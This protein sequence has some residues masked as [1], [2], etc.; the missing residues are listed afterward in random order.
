MRN[1]ASRT[2]P[3]DANPTALDRALAILH[4]LIG[5]EH[6]LGLSEISDRLGIPKP[7][8]HRLLARLQASGHLSRD[9][10]GRSFSVG[11]RLRELSVGAL[12]SVVRQAPQLAALEALTRETGE[13]C[14]VGVLDGDAVVIVERIETSWPIRVHLSSGLRLPLHATAL[15]KLFL[16]RLSRTQ[17]Q[18]YYEASGLAAST[19][20]TITD[21]EALERDLTRIRAED[22]AFNDQGYL[23]G[24]FGIAVPIRP[25]NA[26]KRFVAALSLQTTQAR[27]PPAGVSAFVPA[28]R[29]TAATLSRAIYAED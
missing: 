7:T 14:N 2:D 4:L 16:G 5:Q 23:P 21:P 29:E 27:I 1:A 11:P 3:G 28:L 17:R 20:W 13:S 25:E 8:V 24:I 6:S 26:R 15:G 18:R 22:V 10:A 19:Q 12:A 9:L